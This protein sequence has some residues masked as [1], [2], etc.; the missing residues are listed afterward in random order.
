MKKDTNEEFAPYNYEFK[1]MSD[2]EF[3]SFCEDEFEA[4]TLRKL[5]DLSYEARTCLLQMED[6]VENYEIE[7]GKSD[8]TKELHR[9]ISTIVNDLEALP[10]LL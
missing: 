9:K 10:T 6:E 2:E 4:D 8:R 3:N 5:I 1:G 7:K